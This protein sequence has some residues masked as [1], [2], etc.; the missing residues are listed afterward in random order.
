M[1]FTTTIKSSTSRQIQIT[2]WWQ[3]QDLIH[4]FQKHVHNRFFFN[5]FL[6]PDALLLISGS[7]LTS[8]K[9]FQDLLS[10]D[11]FPNGEDSIRYLTAQD[12]QILSMEVTEN[13][14]AT[15]T[16]GAHYVPTQRSISVAELIYRRLAR[17][18]FPLIFY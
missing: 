10:V 4:R 6:E 2:G 5:D 17:Y 1:E 13:Y 3:H 7:A 16:T 8:S 14:V 12:L 11:K 18:N 15:V 9:V